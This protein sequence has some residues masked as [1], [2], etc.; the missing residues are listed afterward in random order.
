MS[1]LRHFLQDPKVHDGIDRV[2]SY[3]G[4]HLTSINKNKSSNKSNDPL[5]RSPP[6][7]LFTKG[8]LDYLDQLPKDF[9]LKNTAV[10]PRYM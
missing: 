3:G 6:F 5:F 7:L 8:A 2:L 10:S 9:F 1:G 4:N